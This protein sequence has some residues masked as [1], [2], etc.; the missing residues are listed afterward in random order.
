MYFWKIKYLSYSF[1]L[2]NISRFYMY[3]FKNKNKIREYST[4]CDSKIGCIYYH[5]LCKRSVLENVNWYHHQLQNY[6]CQID[7]NEILKS[8]I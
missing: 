3:Y 6:S 4:C 5:V 7:Q 2:K 1:L 8:K